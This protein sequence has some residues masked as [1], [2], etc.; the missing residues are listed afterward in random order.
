MAI[1]EDQE[2]KD[3]EG[4]SKSNEVRGEKTDMSELVWVELMG[5]LRVDSP[6]GWAAEGKERIWDNFWAL[7]NG[8]KNKQ[9]R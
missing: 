9:D 3:S 2:Y 4:L 7:V 5:P 1:S 6:L 8:E